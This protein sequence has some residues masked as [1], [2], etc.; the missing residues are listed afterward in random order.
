MTNQPPGERQKATAAEPSD[1]AALREE[2][3]RTRKELGDTVEALAAKADVGAR[4]K[5]KAAEVAERA[6]QKASEVAD[7]ARTGVAGI[8]EQAAARAGAAR[9]AVADTPPQAIGQVAG[10][11]KTW[12]GPLLLVAAAVAMLAGWLRW[13]RSRRTGRARRRR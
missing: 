10:V 12:R 2:I 9:D 8:K 13:Q 11:A 5:E 6:R 3:L 7:A 1:P 4:A